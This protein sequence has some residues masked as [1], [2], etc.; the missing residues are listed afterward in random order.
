MQFTKWKIRS[1]RRVLYLA[2][3]NPGKIT[4]LSEISEACRIPEKF[5][6]KIFQSLTR[7]GIVRSHRGVHGGFTMARDP[8]KLPV[9][10]VLEADTGA[11]HLYK[12]GC[13]QQRQLQW[14][15]CVKLPPIAEIDWFRRFGS[16][17]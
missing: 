6:A 15:H 11:H 3:Q 17:L 16:I 8:K 1:T 12:R 2:E 13:Q 7:T 14:K 4:P 10:D 5:L 9:K